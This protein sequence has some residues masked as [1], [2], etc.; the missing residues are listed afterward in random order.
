MKTIS[1]GLPYELI[2]RTVSVGEYRLQLATIRNLDEAVDLLCQTLEKKHCGQRERLYDQVFAENLCPYFGQ[3]WPSALGLAQFL[4]QRPLHDVDMLELGAGLAL[5]SMIAAQRGAKV[6]ASD[7]HQDVKAMFNFNCRHNQ[8]ERF[9]LNY[10]SLDWRESLVTQ[11]FS[12]VMA[13]DVLYEGRHPEEVASALTRW[14]LPGGKIIVADQGRG[15]LQRFVSIMEQ[16][17]FVHEVQIEKIPSSSELSHFD[18]R[19]I[20][21][22]TFCRANK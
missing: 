9:N 10:Y 19:E 2:L 17:G 21:V 8:L 7:F 6:V 5:P 22:I 16:Q 1:L 3:L 18:A 14:C 15:Q 11:R 20:F 4:A 13:S 12:V